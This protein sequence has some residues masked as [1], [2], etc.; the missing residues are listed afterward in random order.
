MLLKFISSF[1]NNLNLGKSLE[2]YKEVPLPPPWT[3]QE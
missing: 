2:Q 1:L 3:L